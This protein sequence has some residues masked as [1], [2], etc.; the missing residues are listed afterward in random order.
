MKQVVRCGNCNTIIK[1]NGN[2]TAMLTEMPTVNGMKMP[3]IKLTIKLCREC[4]RKTGY[5]VKN[6]PIQSN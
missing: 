1:R 2:F 3:E 5:K 6:E 4:A